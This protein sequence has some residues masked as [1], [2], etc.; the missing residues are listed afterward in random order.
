MA[1]SFRKPI[2]LHSRVSQMVPVYPFLHVQVSGAVH[3]PPLEHWMEQIAG[4]NKNFGSKTRQVY[5]LP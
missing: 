2:F 3:S 1:Q 5:Y 4:E